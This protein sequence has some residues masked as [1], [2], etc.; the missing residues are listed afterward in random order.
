LSPKSNNKTVSI[1]LPTHNRE[2]YLRR[3]IDSL[4]DQTYRDIVLII[5]D[6][7][8]TDGTQKICEEYAKKDNRVRYIRQKENIGQ[9]G[10]ATLMLHEIAAAAEYCLFVSDD[11]FWD[12]RF[13]E[14]CM[15]QLERE[16]EAGMAFTSHATYFEATGEKYVRDPKLFFP[17]EKDLYGRL[18]RFI[19]SYSYDDRGILMFGIYRNS[20]IAR[21]A[22]WDEYE[23]DV[24][25]FYR[26]L[27]RG[28]VTFADEGIGPLFFKT[29]LPGNESLE[30]ESLTAHRLVSSFKNRAERTKTEF[31]NMRFTFALK[32]LSLRKRCALLLWNLY[33]IGR[34]FVRRKT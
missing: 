21:E 7:A 15:R 3:A 22:F 33:V 31:H 27:S 14:V 17:F 16:P 13:I 1:G 20:I 12:P 23:N 32:E 18:K 34:L 4:L 6:N 11:D 24:S 9:L 2:A 25:F 8:S 30:R 29:I 26:C 5:S 10:N 19:L 28:Y